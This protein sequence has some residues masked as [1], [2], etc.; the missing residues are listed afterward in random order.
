MTANES[1]GLLG[2]GLLDLAVILA[3][4]VV[5]GLIVKR[6]FFGKKKKKDNHLKALQI[7]PV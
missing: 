2:F 7:N 1:D 4:V 5:V 6:I 3:A